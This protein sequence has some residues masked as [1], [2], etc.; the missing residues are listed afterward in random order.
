MIHFLYA[1][2]QVALLLQGLQEQAR[3][4]LTNVHC[5]GFSIGAHVCGFVGRNF[6]RSNVTIG[7]I[8]GIH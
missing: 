2:A 5:V 3:L 7:R 6:A 4:D 1:G 8:S